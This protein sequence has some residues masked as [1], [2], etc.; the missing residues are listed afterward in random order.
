[1]K[2]LIDLEP[3]EE[4]GREAAHIESRAIT[5]MIRNEKMSLPVHVAC[6]ALNAEGCLY[7]YERE[8]G[9]GLLLYMARIGEKTG[10]FPVHYLLMDAKG[11][12]PG[13]S[14]ENASNRRTGRTWLKRLNC[15]PKGNSAE[16]TIRGYQP[17]SEVIARCTNA[18]GRALRQSERSPCCLSKGKAPGVCDLRERLR[19]L[20]I[21]ALQVRPISG[22]TIPSILAQ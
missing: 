3:G 22:G 12:T 17:P 5:E 8:S 9:Q 14:S 20:K 7:R 6:L 18:F 11:K 15:S 2:S 21:K 10:A 1:L 13:S 16:C 4:A 19:C